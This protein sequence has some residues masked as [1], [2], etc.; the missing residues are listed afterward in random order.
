MAQQKV[1]NVLLE[2]QR[3]IPFPWTLAQIEG[4]GFKPTA[5]LLELGEKLRQCSDIHTPTGIKVIEAIEALRQETT[6]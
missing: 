5:L 6:P 4:A 3:L 2:Y 1:K